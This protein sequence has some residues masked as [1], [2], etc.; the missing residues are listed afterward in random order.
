MARCGFVYFLL[1]LPLLELEA[2]P[3]DPTV[4][5]GQASC[6]S[7]PEKLEITAHD[8]TIIS[9]KD[10]SIGSKE[11]TRFNLPNSRS[12]ILNRVGSHNPSKIE[13]LLSS[14]GIVYLLNK[15]GLLITPSGKIETA[16]FLASTLDISDQ[17]FLSGGD[18][19][20]T[21]SSGSITNLGAI[22]CSS[23]DVILIASQLKNDGGIGGVGF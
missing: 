20:F 3:S 18:I 17:D 22:Q 19:L 7:T 5:S 23:G 16:G 2:N 4:V 10:F 11:T 6:I 1:L 21:G 15:N 12:V 13:G 8:K 14:N 9:W